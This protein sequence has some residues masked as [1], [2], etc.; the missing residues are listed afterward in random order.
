M[1]KNNSKALHTKL[2]RKPLDDQLFVCVALREDGQKIIFDGRSE[3]DGKEEEAVASRL[4]D[5]ARNYYR[6]VYISAEV[7]ID[8]QA[9]VSSEIH[10]L[11]MGSSLVS[12]VAHAL[13]G[14]SALINDVNKVLS[15]FV[16]AQVGASLSAINPEYGY[17]GDRG[18]LS[19][20]T[21]K[22]LAEAAVESFLTSRKLKLKNRPLES[23]SSGQRRAAMLDFVM[24]I[25]SS[26][27]G[28]E[29]RLILAVDE[30]EISMDMARR[31]RQFHKLASLV[32]EHT[33]VIFTS[34]WYGWVLPVNRGS[35]VLLTEDPDGER[36]FQVEKS[37]DFP[38]RGMPRYEMR[39]IF[40]FLAAIGSEAEQN[41]LA[42]F[43]ICES[44]SDGLYIQSSL[45]DE[46]LTCV[47]VGKN[48]VKR[49]SAIFKE[50]YWKDKGAKIKNVL[51]L[52]DTDPEHGDAASYGE[53]G[54]LVRWSKAN[55]GTVSLDKGKSNHSNKC[56]I[57]DALE[58]D[59]L[60]QA[61]KVVLSEDELVN[62]IHVVDSNFS[63]LRAFDLKASEYE[64][65]SRSLAANKINIAEKYAEL[66]IN[67][68]KENNK[69]RQEIGDYI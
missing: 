24:A 5:E 26:Q 54:Y 37:A 35:T 9:R 39:M 44:K 58:P 31:L 57:E 7:D 46:K 64:I 20:L 1:L 48:R 43:I 41:P 68:S 23:L 21:A 16:D 22:K 49:I 27:Q 40:D 8:D 52:T 19:Q 63:G 25:L 50:Y 56:V 51:F 18:A 61:L 4:F 55:N 38:F 6:Y 34:H 11:L 60:L 15:D 36:Q 10:E 32:G 3:V 62:G 13:K 67:S 30:P 28:L 53:D 33:S 69:I 12:D 47:P 17:T 29:R 2:K 59:I 42:K 45:N 66:M 65:I 14:Q